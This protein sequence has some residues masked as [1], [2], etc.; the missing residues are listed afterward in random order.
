MLFD[1]GFVLSSKVVKFLQMFF[2]YVCSA[3]GLLV[4][5][6]HAGDQ[7]VLNA[8]AFLTG[9]PGNVIALPNDCNADA[10]VDAGDLD[11]IIAAGGPDGRGT[12]EG[13]VPNPAQD[14]LQMPARGRSG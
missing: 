12:V 1:L 4:L 13:P 3:L 8:I 9:D 14:G 7:I 2:E 10:I 11:C 6:T 5:S